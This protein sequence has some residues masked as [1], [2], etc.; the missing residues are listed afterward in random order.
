MEDN[1]FFEQ[2]YWRFKMFRKLLI[3]LMFLTIPSW[4]LATDEVMTIQGTVHTATQTVLSS[5][6]VATLPAAIVALARRAS[7][8]FITC[9]D[10]DIRWTVGG[11]DP[12]AASL[13]HIL[14]DEGSIRIVNGQWIRTFR[15]VS[16]VALTPARLQI[17]AEYNN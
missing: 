11:V 2:T 17:T 8:V 4:S 10:A 5:D 3:I 15:Y 1:S 13:G 12:I 9:E 6:V 14:Y 7:A 16:A